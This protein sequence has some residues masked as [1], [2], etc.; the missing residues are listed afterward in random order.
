MREVI[1]RVQPI[2]VAIIFVTLAVVSFSTDTSAY[3]LQEGVNAARG[4]SQPADLF[5]AGGVI[6]TITNTLLFIV[7]ALSVIMIIVGGLRYV[8]SGGNAASVTAARNT[9]L[10]AVVGLVIAFLA[11]AAI[12]FVLG[13]VSPGSGAGYTD[14]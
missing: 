6:T 14:V 2:L 7:G 8:V 3:S 5:G 4:S 9:I 1:R 12:N 11:F 13:T 10:Y